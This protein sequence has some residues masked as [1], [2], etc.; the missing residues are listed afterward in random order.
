MYRNYPTLVLQTTRKY[1]S[2]T[3]D[4]IDLQPNFNYLL[5]KTKQKHQNNI[6]NARKNYQIT[7]RK[8]RH[9]DSHYFH[10]NGVEFF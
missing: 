9:E 6:A 7:K 10:Q 5:L 3:S 2:F 1:T 8:K 4:N